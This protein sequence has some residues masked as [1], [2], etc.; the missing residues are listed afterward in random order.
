MPS[1]RRKT[2]PH[3]LSESDS[4]AYT[5]AK[6][7]HGQTISFAILAAPFHKFALSLAEFRKIKRRPWQERLSHFTAVRE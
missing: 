6:R 7:L 5:R 4:H 1:F 2:P 3:R